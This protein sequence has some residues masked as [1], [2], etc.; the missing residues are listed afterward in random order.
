M[1]KFFKQLSIL[2]I[3]A[4]GVLVLVHF[5]FNQPVD[6]WTWLGF[7][8]FVSMTIFLYWLA[9]KAMSRSHKTFLNFVYG[10]SL[11]RFIFSI[12]FIVI[13]LIINEVAGRSFIFSFLFLYLLFTSFEI[14]HL[15]AKLRSEK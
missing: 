11:I 4:G 8:F 14:F 9:E 13:Y 7:A 12:F 15:V 6:S 1:Q 2:T 3:S 10:S 5:L